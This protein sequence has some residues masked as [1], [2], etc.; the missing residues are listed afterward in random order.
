MWGSEGQEGP[1][2]PVPLQCCGH[3]QGR[4]GVS[5]G[6]TCGYAGPTTWRHGVA[7]VAAGKGT[8]PGS[9]EVQHVWAQLQSPACWESKPYEA[10]T[11]T[12]VPATGPQPALH[13]RGF[14][15]SVAI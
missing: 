11:G 3:L 7:L 14:M 4:R 2:L 6:L 12:L 13:S 1:Q 8:R 15:G 10:G 9:R 5:P